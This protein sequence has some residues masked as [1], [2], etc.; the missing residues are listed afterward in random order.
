MD[1]L[2][3]IFFVLAS[4][5]WYEYP[6]I[7]EHVRTMYRTKPNQDIVQLLMK[8]KAYEEKEYPLPMFTVRRTTFRS[9]VINIL[10]N[11]LRR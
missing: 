3:N 11:W 10:M 7:H 9:L 1:A 5:T 8:L 2:C 4:C 6:M